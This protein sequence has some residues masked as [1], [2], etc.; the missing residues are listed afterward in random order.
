MGP[1]WI[2][3]CVF[4]NPKNLTVTIILSLTLTLQFKLYV[5]CCFEFGGLNIAKLIYTTIT[6]FIAEFNLYLTKPQAEAKKAGYLHKT[7]DQWQVLYLYFN[8]NKKIKLIG[9]NNLVK[10]GK[11]ADLLTWSGTEDSGGKH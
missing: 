7:C 2:P 9:K 4:W 3:I 11:L 5:I 8:I 1:F 10:S 6:S